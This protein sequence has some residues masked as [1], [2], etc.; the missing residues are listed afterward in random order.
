MLFLFFYAVEF[1]S[2]FVRASQPPLS[3][4][5][6]Q[7]ALPLPVVSVRVILLNAQNASA[8]SLDTQYNTAIIFFTK[9]CG[10]FCFFLLILPSEN[11]K[12]KK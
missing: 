12:L 9:L 5:S 6:G 3:C 4:R 1:F 11:D 2:R 7:A 8:N 10:M